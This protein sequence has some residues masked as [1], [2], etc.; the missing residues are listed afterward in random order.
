MFYIISWDFYTYLLLIPV[1]LMETG[2]CSWIGTLC[3]FLF[4]VL[5]S[6]PSPSPSLSL[7]VGHS[8]KAY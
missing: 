5:C 4:S 6:S 8:F 7:S 2:V 3:L 1:Q